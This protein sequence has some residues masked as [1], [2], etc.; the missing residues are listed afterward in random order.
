MA[1][2]RRVTGTD[3]IAWGGRKYR[4]QPEHSDR[5][6][7]VYF[8]ATTAPRT[9]LH[10][11]IYEAAHGPIPDGF[12]VHHLNHDP[13]DNRI[14]NLAVLS[15]EAHARYHESK[16]ER[17]EKVCDECGRE[18]TAGADRARWCSPACKE[19]RRRKDGVAYVRPKV[20]R[21]AE[22]RV[23]IECGSEF[24]ARKPWAVYCSGVCRGS[25]GRRRRAGLES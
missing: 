6:R 2:N 1:G 14:E 10:R 12:H 5:H 11:D 22:A 19:R 8:M 17:F 9:Y 23:C 21:M 16:R 3:E 4:R 15:P 7:R 25:A 18:F 13:L 24:T 20:G